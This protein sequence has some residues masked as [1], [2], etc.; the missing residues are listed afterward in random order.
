MN[1][2]AEQMTK[3]RQKLPLLSFYPVLDYKG[4]E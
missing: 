3:D 2:I 1:C 4:K